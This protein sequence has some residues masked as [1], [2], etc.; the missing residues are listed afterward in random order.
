MTVYNPE[1]TVGINISDGQNPYGFSGPTNSEEKKIKVVVAGKEY[2]VSEFLSS[3]GAYVD[4]KLNESKENILKILSTFKFTDASQANGSVCESKTLKVKFTI[5]QNW[6]CE[7]SGS[8][9]FVALDIKGGNLEIL[10]NNFPGEPPCG[11]A[12]CPSPTKE[13]YKSD[14]VTLEQYPTSGRVIY[15][16][17]NNITVNASLVSVYV[18]YPN[19]KSEDISATEKNQLT[20]ILNSLTLE[21]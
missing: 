1:K 13:F 10:L 5:P 19:M 11:E 2:V 8:S 7:P 17:L 16:T 3:T 14:K 9:G 18:T 4:F 21:N 15:G 12:A 20:N 6:T